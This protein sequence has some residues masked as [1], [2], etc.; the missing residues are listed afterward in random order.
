MCGIHLILDKRQKLSPSN[1]LP[2]ESMMLSCAYRGPD[3]QGFRQ[4]TGNRQQ[5]WLAANRLK[6]MDPSP[7]ADQP[8]V[9]PCSRY[10]LLYNGELYNFYELR[11]QL[12]QEGERFNTHADTEVLLKLLIRKG[13]EALP[14]LHG[15]FAFAFY[16][17]QEETLLAARDRSGMKPLYFFENSHYLILSSETRSILASGLVQK[18]LDEAQIDH[19]LQYKY[20]TPGRTFFKNIVALLPGHILEKKDL[21]E[22]TIVPFTVGK[23]PPLALPQYHLS[24]SKLLD[25]TENLL[26]DAVL[27]HLGADVPCGLFLSGGVDSTLLLS[28]IQK[29]G[30]HPIPTF[31]ILNEANERSFGTEDY[32]YARK[33]AEMY[34][35]YH[36]EL[37]L[38]PSL[39]EEAW[40]TYLSKT[41]QPIGD[42]ASL[43]T[44]L[45]A[46][47]AKKAVGVVLS[48]AGADE[49]FAGYNRHQAFQWYLK[50]YALIKNVSPAIKLGRHLPT[51]FRHP[52]RKSFRLLKKMSQS[53]TEDPATTYQNFVRLSMPFPTGEPTAVTQPLTEPE[54]REE[55]Y[56]QYALDQDLHHYLVY[57]I[58][59]LSDQMSMAQSLEMRMPY[60]DNP[61]IHFATQ[62]SPRLRLRHGPK[63]ILRQLLERNGGRLFTRRKKEGFG[64]PT[65]A[66]L[67]KEKFHFLRQ[68]LENPQAL[69]FQ[70]IAFSQVQK[71]L[72][73]HV[74][75]KAD[76]SQELWALLLLSA[77][78]SHHFE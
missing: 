3:A 62:L 77:W 44:F 4:S 21:Q 16:D 74:R 26:T 6:I 59:T 24:E 36:Y 11:N 71:M 54:P 60:L 30:A 76:Y 45:L 12:L 34:G 68:P 5:A 47:E 40:H 10:L 58:L 51:G 7:V 15:M 57:D 67:R 63:W 56:L 39:I 73:A 8:M 43:M 53:I 1:S 31:S 49:L 75:Q 17:Q 25:E 32:H 55:T 28:I 37:T 22:K 46:R 72:H 66:W 64:L 33:A 35:Q 52:W 19:Y 9:S 48:G 78:L 29:Q 23:E 20:A 13:K 50:N 14:Q 38:Q 65:G 70:Y 61:L 69:L 42:S 27:R 41:D 2:I 18:E